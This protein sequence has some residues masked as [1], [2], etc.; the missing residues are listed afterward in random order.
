MA[1]KKKEASKKK[2]TLVLAKAPPKPN[3]FLTDTLR[4]CLIQ[5]PKAKVPNMVD[6]LFAIAEE[7]RRVADTLDRIYPPPEPAL[8]SE[9]DILAGDAEDEDEEEEEQAPETLID[10]V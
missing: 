9:D 6:G 8:T 3:R 2:P 5:N 1:T 7:F 10:K 4:D